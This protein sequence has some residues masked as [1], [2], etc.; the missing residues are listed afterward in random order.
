MTTY[1]Q[2]RRGPESRKVVSG[3][4][5]DS[6]VPRT[7]WRA[8]A[9]TRDRAHAHAC[10]CSHACTRAMRMHAR[11]HAGSTSPRRFLA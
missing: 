1:S 8:C 4:G 10:A 9:G 5:G 3:G 7:Q 11:T 6:E 2:W